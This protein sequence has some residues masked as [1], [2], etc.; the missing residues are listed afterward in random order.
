MDSKGSLML[1]ELKVAEQRFRALWE[2][3]DGAAVTEAARFRH[4]CSQAPR[5][6]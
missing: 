3:L 4:S 5:V 1:A 2:V 6:V